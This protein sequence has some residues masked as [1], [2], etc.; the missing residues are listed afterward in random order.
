MYKQIIFPIIA[1]GTVEST[2]MSIFQPKVILQHDETDCGAACLSTICHFYGKRIPITRIRILAG[3]DTL[4]TSGLGIIKASK[5]LGFLTKGARSPEKKV[6]NSIPFPII[7]HVKKNVLDHYVVVFRM[8][9]K[10]V[11]I[12]DPASGYEVWSWKDFEEKWTGVFFVMVPEQRFTQTKE[13]RGLFERFFYLIKPHGGILREIFLSSI[14]LTILGVVGAFYYRFL[15]D[16]VLSSG[17]PQALLV[18][19]IGMVLI[20]I[21]QVILGMSRNQLVMHMANKIDALLI[22]QYFA[23][24]LRL[25]MDFFSKR[26]TGEI[27]SRLGD[28]AT[29]RQAISGTT[30][31]IIIDSLMLVIG[32]G[33]LF[34][35]S[36]DLVFIALIPLLLSA[37]LIWV[38]AKPYKNMIKQRA[39]TDAEKHSVFVETFNGIGTIKTLSTEDEVFLKAEEKVVDSI[40]QGLRIGFWGNLQGSIQNFLSQAGNLAVFWLG[41]YFILEGRMSLGELISFNTLLGYFL[42]PL[43]RLITLQPSLQEAFVASDRLGEILDIPDE[44]ENDN[45]KVV[46]E[47]VEGNIKIEKL[48]FSYGTRGDTIKDVSLSIKAGQKVAFVGPSGSGKT[49]MT[50]LLMKFFP[51]EEGD[52]SLDEHNLKDLET[53]SFRNHVGYVP[54]EIL[55]FSGSIAEN[56]AWGMPTASPKDIVEAAIFAQAHEFISKLPDRYGTY[57]GERGATLSGGERQRIALARV[58][59]R[60]P[61]ILILDEATSSL[62]SVSEKAIMQTVE[63][64]S[65]SMTT[66]IVA[67]RL[68]T[69]KNCDQIFVMQEGNLVESGKH[70]E[71]LILDGIYKN[72]WESQNG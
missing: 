23:H 30:L 65:R 69:I 70:E 43:G 25:P 4:G 19:G 8:T 21:F 33:F 44:S 7:V 11:W 26:K 49:T 18:M 39:I 20:I 35:F 16:E 10:K 27:L 46:L 28:T 38:Y 14:L 59:L 12:G 36:F 63:N 71:L 61:K 6:L 24:V 51:W 31:T 45:G 60:K 55:L 68:S 15:I 17:L 2:D 41:S 3:T 34:L 40:Q 67:H 66:I 5:I 58:I 32:G 52:I 54:Q 37:I 13:T 50:K 72:L 57:V 56:I 9:E 1:D 48:R 62:D 29:I 53:E 42:G 22:F 47:V 64:L